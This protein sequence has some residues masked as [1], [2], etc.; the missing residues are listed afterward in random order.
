MKLT[1]GIYKLVGTIDPE[2]KRIEEVITNI[3]GDLVS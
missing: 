1:I 2:T 3:C